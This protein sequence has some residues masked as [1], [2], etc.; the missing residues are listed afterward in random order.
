[1]A[2]GQQNRQPRRN[3]QNQ[4]QESQLQIAT[5]LLKTYWPSV[6]SLLLLFSFHGGSPQQKQAIGE[7]FATL[8]VSL[9]GLLLCVHIMTELPGLKWLKKELF[10]WV[11]PKSFRGRLK[12][13]I[14]R[15]LLL[16]FLFF[17]ILGAIFSS[18]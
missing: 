18:T 6:L 13:W 10:N 7:L 16:S 1:M 5:R 2:N 4:Q 17:F 9:G 11:L 15:N 3:G 12:S 14:G 8:L